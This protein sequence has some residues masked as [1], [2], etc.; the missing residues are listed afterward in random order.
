VVRNNS[1]GRA[2]IA[3]KQLRYI[4]IV[5][6]VALAIAAANASSTK[7]APQGSFLRY[8]VASVR[9]LCDQVSRE[10]S[11]SQLYGKHF[12][13]SPSV[14]VQYFREHLRLTKLTRPMR[15]TV[16]GATPT[17]RIFVKHRTLAK[18]TSVFMTKNGK[19]VLKGVC[20][21]PLSARLPLAAGEI[22]KEAQLKPAIASAK[23]NAA[24]SL[25]KSTGEVAQLPEITGETAPINEEIVTKTLAAPGEIAPAPIVIL[26]AQP[27][28]I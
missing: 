11:V 20:G 7:R 17:G 18:G 6:L 27:A 13:M 15:V 25:P 2:V 14:I 21:N 28:P 23:Q 12:K 22:G 5:L 19:V 1:G 16:Y 4:L 24:I 10:K 26:P 9:Q 3:L 8:R